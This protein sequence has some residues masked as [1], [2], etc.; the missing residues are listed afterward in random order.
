MKLGEQP[1]LSAG[2]DGM[3]FKSGL[4]E[5]AES[6]VAGQAGQ[7]GRVFDDYGGWH[8]S[9]LA[10][11]RLCLNRRG[12]CQYRLREVGLEMPELE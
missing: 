12:V 5:A 2:R 10:N 3:V 1:C 8:G 4:R 6:G 7:L 11:P 9:I